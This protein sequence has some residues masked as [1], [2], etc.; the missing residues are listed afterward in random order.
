MPD[1]HTQSD[2]VVVI[3]QF[4]NTKWETLSGGEK[5]TEITKV[6]PA[7]KR[8]SSNVEGKSAVSAITLTKHIERGVDDPIILWGNAD[9]G[10]RQPAR[11][12]VRKQPITKQGIPTGKATR[13]LR[14]KVSSFND[15]E[16]DSSSGEAAMMTITLEPEDKV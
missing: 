3:D 13:Y 2:Y 5:T 4:P 6:F 1:Y 9:P 7:G 8:T 15:A 16:V 11:V 14:C 10:L 12:M